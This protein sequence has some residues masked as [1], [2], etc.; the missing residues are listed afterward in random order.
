MGTERLR[1]REDGAGRVV[2]GRRGVIEQAGAYWAGSG[3]AMAA[4]GVRGGLPKVVGF[5]LAVKSDAFLVRTMSD[6]VATR[7]AGNL[8]AGEA[9]RKRVRAA[10]ER[11]RE[12]RFAS[13]QTITPSVELGGRQDGGDAETGLGSSPASASSTPTRVW[14]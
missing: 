8:A 5:T 13:R 3:L 12:L 11:S 6:A 1:A 7:G 9:E 10:L 14:V 2:R 4:V